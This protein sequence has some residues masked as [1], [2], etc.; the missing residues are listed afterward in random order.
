MGE[1]GLSSLR[2]WLAGLALAAVSAIAASAQAQP[3][4]SDGAAIYDTRCKACHDGG[5]PRAPSKADLGHRAPA[6]IVTALTSGIMVPMA[7][8]LSDDD[9]KAVA[10]YLTS[11][12]GGGGARRRRDRRG[13]PG[14][15]CR[16]WR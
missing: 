14:P 16:R 4:A 13:P 5:N 9:K 12:S 15:R 11:A 3:A 1:L 7:Q 10:A 8:G 2:I 6:D